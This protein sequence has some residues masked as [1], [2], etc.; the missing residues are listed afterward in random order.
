MKA[1][2]TF[3]VENF[4]PAQIE[5]GSAIETALPV[6]IA[7]MT[8]RYTGEI[9]G[10]SST[11]FTAAFDPAAGK[12]TYVAME[13]FEGIVNG[14]PGSFNFIHSAS[15]EGGSRE[16][17]LFRVIDGSGTQELTRISGTGGI[18]VDG[19]GTHRIWIDYRL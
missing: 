12:G 17:E 19:D 5:T 7:T 6:S 2:A 13:S 3:T 8:K 1:Q 15:T 14:K 10:I 18:S 4:K 9:A 11:I 16:N